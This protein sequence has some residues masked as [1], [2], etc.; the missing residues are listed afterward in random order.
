ML[1]VKT[2]QETGASFGPCYPLKEIS[3]YHGSTLCFSLFTLLAQPILIHFCLDPQSGP[4]ASSFAL[5]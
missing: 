1:M 2:D 3:F 5:L 4:P